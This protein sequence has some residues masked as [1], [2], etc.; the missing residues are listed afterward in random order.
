MLICFVKGK[1]G[2]IVIN[3][4]K[5]ISFR[6]SLVLKNNLDSVPYQKVFCPSSQ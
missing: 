4:S 1:S 5:K 6:V 2:V 3:F